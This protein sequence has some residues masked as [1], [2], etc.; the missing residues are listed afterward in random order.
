[1]NTENT[2]L[3]SNKDLLLESYDFDLPKELIAQEP[4]DKRDESKLLVYNNGKIE[5]LKFKDIV[6]YFREGDI[7]VYNSTRVKKTKIFGKK[8]TGGRVEVTLI[9]RLNETRY[10]CLLKMKNPK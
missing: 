3:T 5:H 9:K 4:L 2:N 7:I 10:Q 1:M 8:E 6:K